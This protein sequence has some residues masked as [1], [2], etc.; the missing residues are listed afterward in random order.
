MITRHP[1]TAGY[2]QAKKLACK[3]EKRNAAIDRQIKYDSLTTKEKI[4]LAKS[5]RGK[6]KKE[7]ARLGA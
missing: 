3:T 2:T 6:S 7:L 1:K 4:D 5:K